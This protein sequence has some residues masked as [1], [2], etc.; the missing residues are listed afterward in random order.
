MLPYVILVIS[1]WTYEHTA[2]HTR[3]SSCIR[4]MM[5]LRLINEHPVKIERSIRYIDEK[6]RRK[7]TQMTKMNQNAFYCS[8]DFDFLHWRISCFLSFHM[9]LSIPV[10]EWLLATCIYFINALAILLVHLIIFTL[11]GCFECFAFA[12]RCCVCA[13]RTYRVD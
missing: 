5:V 1:L 3:L 8:L 4:R 7:H 6:H 9:H 2:L 13:V 12:S 11:F 10:D